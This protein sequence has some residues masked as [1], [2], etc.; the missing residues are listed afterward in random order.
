MNA[1]SIPLVFAVML[2]AGC[3]SRPSVAVTSSLG[4]HALKGRTVAVGG[5]AA[6]DVMTYPGQTAEAL[7][8][9]DAGKAL[10]HRFKH[11]YAMTAEATWSVAGPPATKVNLGIPLTLGHKPTPDFMRRTRAEG[12]DYLLWID[13]LENSVGK[14]SKQWVSTRSSRSLS[15]SG[16]RSR[17][18]NVYPNT[19]TT[20]VAYHRSE[21]ASRSLGASYTLLDTATGRTV[22]RADSKLSG[23]NV[24]YS[25][26]PTGYPAPP[27]VPLPPEEDVLMK[28]MTAAA[29]DALP[30]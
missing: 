20:V 19:L 10:R 6:R 1:L 12:V 4:S 14:A 9:C 3:A 16:S 30:K 17:S 8:V 23:E 22:W 28:R 25:Q 11:S 24:N 26:S 18:T 5:F 27:R 21:S 7:I 13:L 2:A 15:N 29:I